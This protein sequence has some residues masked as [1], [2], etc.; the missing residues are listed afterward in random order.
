[1]KW[2]IVGAAVSLASACQAQAPDVTIK[3]DARLNYRTAD[4]DANTQRLYDSLGNYSVVSLGF[5]L[6]PGF[7]VFVS[8]KL[9]RFDGGKDR[10]L[11]DE[12]YVEDEGIWRVGKQYLPFGSGRLV[13]ESVFAARGDTSLIFEGLPI[14][15]AYAQGEEDRQQGIVGR[16][17]G[18]LGVSVFYGDHFGIDGTSL[19]L[20]RKPDQALGRNRGYK[21]AIGVDYSK[22]IGHFNLAVEGVAFRKPNRSLDQSFEVVDLSATYRS[23]KYHNY[24]VGWTRRTNPNADFWR[25][26][27]SIFLTNNVY[28]EPLVRYR[29]G[30]AYDFNLAI[31]VKL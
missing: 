25:L 23:S 3:L 9:Q 29:N 18:R 15:A 14:A 31:R 1:M 8:Q 16:I 12:Y 6:E 28:M 22:G 11:L 20:I 13:R 30:E 21:Q 24:T 26:Q 2:I 19:A 4:E 5:K 27:G 17:G 7:K 10:D